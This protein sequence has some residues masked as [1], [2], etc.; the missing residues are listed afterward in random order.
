MHY[1]AKRGIA[2]AEFARR[3]SICLSIRLSVCDVTL[4]DQDHIGLGWK[5][6]K[7]TARAI[8]SSSPKGHPPIPG[9]SKGTMGKLWGR[10][11][12]GWP[13]LPCWRAGAQKR[14]SMKRVK[15][16]D[17]LLWRGYRNSPT[18][19]RT[20]PSRPRRSPLCLLYTS[21]SPRD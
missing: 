17:K 10:L 9:Y 21:P 2:I 20:V 7:L 13:K 3:P 8:S 16:E 14:Q 5:S 19:F 1:S 15:L 11:E 12:L 18:L 4:V 6:W